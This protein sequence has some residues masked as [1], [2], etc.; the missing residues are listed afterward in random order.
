MYRDLILKYK[1]FDLEAALSDLQQWQDG[2]G[3]TLEDEVTN[4]VLDAVRD[5]IF[6][7]CIFE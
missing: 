7:N 4:N 2:L 5:I 3:D 6:Y 1:E